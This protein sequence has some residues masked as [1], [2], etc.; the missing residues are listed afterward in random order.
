MLQLSV[1]KIGIIFESSIFF[2][3]YLRLSVLFNIFANEIVINVKS[4]KCRNAYG[5]RLLYMDI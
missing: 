4:F 3:I 1:A 5:L 2:L